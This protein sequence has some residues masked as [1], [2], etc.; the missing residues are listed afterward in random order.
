MAWGWGCLWLASNCLVKND[1]EL[2][3]LLSLPFRLE[4]ENTQLI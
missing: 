2:L 4:L 1:L 3:I